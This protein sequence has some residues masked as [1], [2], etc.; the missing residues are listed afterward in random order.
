MSFSNTIQ[1]T[2]N[3]NLI[4]CFDYTFSCNNN[5][6]KRELC[7]NCNQVSYINQYFIFELPYILPII[8]TS[9]NNY[10]FI[11][12]DKIKLNEYEKNDLINN[13]NSDKNYKLISMLCQ[14][15]YNQKFICYCINSNNGL[16]Y[17]YDDGKINKVENM[18]INAIPLIVFYQNEEII[19]FQYNK[20]KRDD[21]NKICLNFSFTNQMPDLKL[22][23]N[24][25]TGIKNVIQC[26]KNIRHLEE[27]IKLLKSGTRV[28]DEQFLK[29][30]IDFDKD[31][32]DF[33]VHLY[34]D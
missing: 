26:I 13:N 18:D 9:N 22:L 27:N 2:N 21:K 10:N 7:I 14:L 28:N 15:I 17:S 32:L 6:S 3:F 29:D 30:L 4:D 33:T 5:I 19:K 1:T 12:Q 11:L 25:N 31:Y 16:W 24:K 20:I 23:F 8:L 34:K